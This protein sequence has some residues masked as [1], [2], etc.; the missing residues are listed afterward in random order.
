MWIHW[1]F[2]APQTSEKI[3]NNLNMYHNG[4][5]KYRSNLHNITAQQ[6]KPVYLYLRPINPT[7]S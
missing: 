7:S 6:E 3:K 5:D 4:V 1:N 2:K